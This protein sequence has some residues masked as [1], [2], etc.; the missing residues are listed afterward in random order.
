MIRKIGQRQLPLD[1]KD[2][3]IQSSTHRSFT[4][5]FKPGKLD[6]SD[7]YQRAPGS[8]FILTYKLLRHHCPF[9]E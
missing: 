2:K 6:N 3:F 9:F 1:L 4:E 7:E 8:Q 5:A